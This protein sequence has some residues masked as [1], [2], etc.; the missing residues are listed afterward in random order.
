MARRI[1]LDTHVWLWMNQSPA[2]LRAESRALL[3]NS[4]NHL[5]LSAVS[6]WEIAV[7]HQ[8]GKLDLPMAPVRYIPERMAEN[9]VRALPIDVLH[10]LRAASLPLHH[11]DPFDRLLV[12]QAQIEGLELMTADRRMADYEVSLLSA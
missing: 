6:T 3:E 2:R 1:L 11:R 7:K 5:L 10:T 4:Q 9:M 8:L 12:A